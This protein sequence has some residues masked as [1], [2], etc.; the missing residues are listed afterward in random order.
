MTPPGIVILGG[1]AAGLSLV[2][3][4]GGRGWDGAVTVIDDAAHPLADRAWAWWSR[5][6]LLLD[7]AASPVLGVAR[8]AG[9]SWDRREPLAPFAYRV[10]TGAA[11][12]REAH[13][14]ARPVERVRGTARAVT[15]RRDDAVVETELED[16]RVVT[17]IARWVLDGVG[18]GRPAPEPAALLDFEGLRVQVDRDA[19]DPTA[20]TLMDF[21][22][23]QESGLAFVY[24]LPTSAR[25]A[26]VERTVF[27]APD[28]RPVD[29]AGELDL[30]LRDV[31][32]LAA[33]RIVAREE[34]VIPL[35]TAPPPRPHGPVVPLG[36]HAGLVRASTGYGFAAIQRHGVA[37][38]QALAAGRDPGAVPPPAR[39]PRV[40]DAALLRIVLNDPEAALDL[41]RALLTRQPLA[42]VLRFLDG[43]APAAA[44]AR[45]FASMP[46]FIPASVH[47]ALSRRRHP[48][49][50]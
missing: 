36:A 34:G 46:G 3:A 2:C 11:L 4:L 25:E 47:A 1:G 6:D 49:P 23:S 37:L 45:I 20:V 22:T 26:L 38:A 41:F 14:V 30:Y 16:G 19:F 42:H 31:L 5:G 12:A 28:A 10:L 33:S 43:D 32:G 29:H 8:V 9:A 24:V 15:A 7:G 17:H 50:G 21:R 35:V 27:V 44:Q 39:W 13:R 18:V 40:L 48:V